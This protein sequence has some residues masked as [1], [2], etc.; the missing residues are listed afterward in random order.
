MASQDD[1]GIAFSYNHE[2]Q[3]Y[4]LLE[5]PSALLQLITSPNPQLYDLLPITVV[6][7]N[8]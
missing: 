8:V 6:F 2:Q 3:S 5:L 4:R 7:T 1:A